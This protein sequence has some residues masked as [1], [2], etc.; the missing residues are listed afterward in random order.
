MGEGTTVASWTPAIPFGAEEL[1]RFAAPLKFNLDFEL[2]DVLQIEFLREDYSA[3]PRSKHPGALVVPEKLD[4]KHL[5]TSRSS[6]SRLNLSGA[7]KRH[8][9]RK[10]TVHLDINK[11]TPE[12]R[13]KLAAD[14]VKLLQ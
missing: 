11:C 5:N 7:V 12:Q 6:K 8:K 14:A 2:L 9:K 3:G 1:G 4:L 10:Q 13:D